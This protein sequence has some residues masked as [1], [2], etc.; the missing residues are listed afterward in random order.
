MF[1]KILSPIE[2][3]EREDFYGMNERYSGFGK[4]I[5]QKLKETLPLVFN[6]LMFYKNV[7]QQV[8]HSYAVYMDGTKSFALQLDPLCEVIVLWDRHNSHVEIGA[9]SQ[10]EYTEAI[11][12]IKTR[13]LTERRWKTAH[14]DGL[15]ASWAEGIILR[16]RNNNQRQLQSEAF[17]FQIPNLHKASQR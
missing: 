3:Y 6:K 17:V 12:F 7:R 9:W 10:D 4:E 11:E 16:H 15:C 13:L 14:N 2:D 8:S 5:Y 1:D